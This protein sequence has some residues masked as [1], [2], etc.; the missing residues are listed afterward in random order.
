LDA[1]LTEVG[2]QQCAL[3]AERTEVL[4]TVDLVVTSPLTR[5]VQTA[6]L[7]FPGQLAAGVP[8][9]ALECVRECCNSI[10]DCRYGLFRL[11]ASGF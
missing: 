3:L 10:C 6:V 2:A 9:V 8:F 5:C 11:Q 4:T 1:R 7:G